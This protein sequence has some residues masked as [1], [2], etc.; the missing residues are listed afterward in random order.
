MEET[1]DLTPT[2]IMARRLAAMAGVDWERLLPYPGYER[3]VWMH[4]ALKMLEATRTGR[5]N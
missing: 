3:N 2:E 5:L 1:E 4:E